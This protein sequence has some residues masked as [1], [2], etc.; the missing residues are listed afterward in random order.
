[1]AISPF[2]GFILAHVVPRVKRSVALGMHVQ[3]ATP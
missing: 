1:M 2:Q 3:I